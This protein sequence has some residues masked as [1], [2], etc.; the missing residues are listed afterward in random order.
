M[1]TRRR[2]SPLLLVLA[3][4]FPGA[5]AGFFDG[6]PR[7]A[8]V[9]D[10]VSWT[11]VRAGSGV[12]D[13]PVATLRYLRLALDPGRRDRPFDSWPEREMLLVELASGERVVFERLSRL[14]GFAPG[15]YAPVS[16]VGLSGVALEV[17]ARA[18]A[19]GGGSVCGADFQLLRVGARELLMAKE[20]REAESVKLALSQ[21]ADDF[22]GT[23]QVDTVDT[24]VRVLMR[25]D[26]ARALA[27][28]ALEGLRTLFPTRSFPTGAADDLQFR[29]LTGEP[30]DPAAGE[31]RQVTDAPE[32]HAGL[33]AF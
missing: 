15:D 1:S 7:S 4:S 10:D 26:R 14:D 33:P 2:L 12:E 17:L 3:I 18:A 27:G 13:D 30:L 9:R 28:G 20:D 5:A 32:L 6:L 31:W 16:R 19:P 25:A 21:L 24:A 29:P 11:V 22:L 23:R 8:Y